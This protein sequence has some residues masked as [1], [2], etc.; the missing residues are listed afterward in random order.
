M[1]ERRDACEVSMGETG[2]VDYMEDAG[3][4]GRIILK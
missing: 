2:E 1:G 4:D 3:R